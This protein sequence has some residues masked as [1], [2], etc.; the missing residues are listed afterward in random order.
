M[1]L[2]NFCRACVAGLS[3][4]LMAS[5]A[6]ASG[7]LVPDDPKLPP[8][9]ITDHLVDIS[10]HERVAITEITQTFHNDYP[11]RVE[12][13]YIFPLPEGADLTNFEMS[14]NGKMVQG[15]ILEADKARHIYESI[16]RQMKDPGL[17]EFIGTRLLQMRIFPIEPDSDTTI[18]LRYQQVTKPISG[19]NGY[20]YP[21]R[22]SKTSGQAYGTVRFEAELETSEPLKNIWSPTHS[23]EIVRNG[24]N[25]AH[26]AYEASGGSLEED[27]MLL[28]ST[29]DSDLGMSVIAHK[30][31]ERR[32]GHFLLLLTP[33]QLWPEEEYTPQDV[34]FVI[35]TSGSMAGEK[36]QQAKQALR[37]TVDALDARDR[38][39]V[40]RFSTGFDV[41]FDDVVEANDD[42]KGRAAE[43]IEK[44][45][46]AGGTNISDTLVHVAGMQSATKG[47]GEGGRPFVVVFITDGEGN[48][49]PDEVLSD[50]EGV[51]GDDSPMRIFPFG[52]GNDVNTLFLD[53][54]AKEY[55]GRPVYVQP[56]EN[57]E[58]VLGDFFATISQ[59]VLTN[60]RIEMPDIG[61]TERFPPTLG[62][63]YHGQQLTIAGKF[64]DEKSGPLTL[65][66]L[67]NGEMV[68]YTWDGIEFENT[69]EADYVASIWAGRKIAF[70]IDEIREHGENKEM[71]DEVISLSQEYGIQTP[72]TSWL[73]NPEQTI[74]LARRGIV[75][76]DPGM[77][78]MS[79]GG[80]QRLRAL[81]DR[82]SS[83]APSRPGGGGGGGFGGGSGIGGGG[84]AAG[85]DIFEENDGLSYDDAERAVR[86]QVGRDATIIAEYQGELRE[87]QSTDEIRLVQDALAARRIAGRMFLRVG[88]FLV[89]QTITAEHELIAIEFGSNAYFELVSARPDLR[90]VFAAWRNAAVAVT[91]KAA[92]VIVDPAGEEAENEPETEV[93][94]VQEFTEI[95]RE[96]L[97]LGDS[98]KN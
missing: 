80:Q 72:Y 57:L 65:R 16:V 83:P 1:S 69:E 79:E 32:D 11:H 27:F 23:V 9:R 41:L 10:I 75:P 62:D 42:N 20:H 33:K 2:R 24:E 86:E 52:V 30:P 49:T 35:D 60:L 61:I 92:V 68:E 82:A 88:P 54:L 73:V 21:L 44:F 84:R 93:Q 39:S 7:L 48:R 67:R 70:L 85:G 78:M 43:F 94:A 6:G 14:F 28:Y 37:Y 90:P 34:V 51:A 19:M 8:L 13:T 17:I 56:G 25:K 18:E 58:L 76:M 53:R 12:A 98:R 29:D 66:G 71:I 81:E 87:A 40:V 26:V 4:F 74:E 31:S 5:G 22:T 47:E 38:F 3:T 95:M 89:D 77:P 50:L 97:E 96:Q 63:L 45:S 15:E 59:P 64:S 36:L 46:A 91:E 55:H